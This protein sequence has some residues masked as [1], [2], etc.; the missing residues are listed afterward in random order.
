M[1]SI[2]YSLQMMTSIYIIIYSLQNGFYCE[3]MLYK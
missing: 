2:K 3:K 1:L